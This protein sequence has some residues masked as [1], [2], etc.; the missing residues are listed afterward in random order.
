MKATRAVLDQGRG[1]SLSEIQVML[2]SEEESNLL[3]EDV[4]CFLI[5]EFG[6]NNK[7][8]ESERRNESQFVCSGA[9]KIED[10]MNSLLNINVVKS[11]AEVIKKSLLEIDYNWDVSFCDAQDFK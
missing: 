3:N 11:A 7:F 9:T 1:L 2:N 4:K 5:E 10:V 8:S 6:H